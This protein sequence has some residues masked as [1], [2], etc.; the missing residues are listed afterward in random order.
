MGIAQQLLG[1]FESG[2]YGYDSMICEAELFALDIHQDWEEGS[3]IFIFK[4]DTALE[5]C[6]PSLCAFSIVDEI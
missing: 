1:N 4:D 6:G 5:V 3:T 2:N